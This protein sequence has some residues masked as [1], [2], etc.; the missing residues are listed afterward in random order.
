MQHAARRVESDSHDQ[1]SANEAPETTR[2]T[3]HDVV[4]R[5]VDHAKDAIRERPL[6][7]VAGAVIVGFVAGSLTP[8]LIA[9]PIGVLALRALISRVAG[10][11]SSN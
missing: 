5:L 8:K 4:W 7:A 6:T 3:L 9:Q 11:A 2:V 1:P 10:N